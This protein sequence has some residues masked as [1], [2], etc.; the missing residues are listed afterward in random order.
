MR[1]YIFLSLAAA[2]FSL[3][4]QAQPRISFSETQ[5][6]FGQIMWR[7]PAQTIF[8]VRNTGNQPL[9]IKAVEPDCGCT[10]V[11]WD[12]TSIAPGAE[13][14]IIAKYDAELLGHFY[15][16]IAVYTNIGENPYYLN[17]VGHVVMPSEGKADNFPVHLGDKWLSTEN[18]E[19]DD[20]RRGD[21]PERTVEVFNA[22]KKPM[23]LG[24]MHLP[25]YLDADIQPTVL[26]PGRKAKI[27]L[28]LKSDV[29]MS[30]GLTQASIYLSTYTGER[31]NRNNEINVSVTLLPDNN[32]SE[33]TLALAPIA[34]LDSTHVELGSLGNKKRL[35]T[36]LFLSNEG[37][38]PLSVSALQVYNAG[39]SVSLD[40]REIKPGE[41]AKMKIIVNNST[42]QFKGRR[43]ILLIT[44]DPRTPKLAIDVNV[45]K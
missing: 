38:S 5:Y 22:G 17:L 36:Q 45:K 42:L 31:I 23:T 30:M 13:G 35:H 29:V 8:R 40:R 1:K 32:Y 33:A 41:K 24:L 14:K 7:N 21:R 43:R 9:E 34:H 28:T 18:V 3:G 11:S 20:V 44:N 37:K 27:R 6:D 2:L 4:M 26:H 12:Q 16:G 25:Q 10:L 19:F 39:I 15:K